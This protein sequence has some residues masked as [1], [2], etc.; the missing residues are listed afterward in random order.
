MMAFSASS[1]E[2]FDDKLINFVREYPV[3]EYR[4]DESHFWNNAWK[5]VVASNFPHPKS[6]ST[7]STSAM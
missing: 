6:V 3:C 2:D 1:C 4:N 7:S 5:A